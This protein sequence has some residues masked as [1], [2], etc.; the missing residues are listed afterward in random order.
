M[1]QRQ[2]DRNH[3]AIHPIGFL[4]RHAGDTLLNGVDRTHAACRIIP[5]GIRIN[6]AWT[7]RSGISSFP[8]DVISASF[9]SF[10]L[11]I[12]ISDGLTCFTLSASCTSD[13]VIAPVER[14]LSVVIAAAASFLPRS[15]SIV[16]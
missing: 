15:D 6:I 14:M 16:F 1:V 12:A 4:H 3:D 9:I 10:I 7:I 13:I 11:S 8:A 5:F 2:R